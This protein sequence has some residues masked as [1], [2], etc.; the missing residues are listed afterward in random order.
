MK[1]YTSP[2]NNYALVTDITISSLIK[3][4]KESYLKEEKFCLL[5]IRKLKIALKISMIQVDT[6]CNVLIC[7]GH[8][9]SV[10]ISIGLCWD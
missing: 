5:F 6:L 3:K 9:K 1:T 10:F 4:W 7:Y 8:F 2:G